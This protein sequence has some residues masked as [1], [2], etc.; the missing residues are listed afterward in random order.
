MHERDPNNNELMTPTQSHRAMRI[1]PDGYFG[2]LGD[3]L[4]D[5][6]GEEVLIKTGS[7]ASTFW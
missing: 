7:R 2:I 1:V 3:G 4:E 5:K 6:M